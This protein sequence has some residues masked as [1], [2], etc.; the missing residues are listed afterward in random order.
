MFRFDGLR[1]MFRF[2]GLRVVPMCI[3]LQDCVCVCG[4]EGGVRERVRK[5]VF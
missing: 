3:G 2:D 5:H 1:G 4:G